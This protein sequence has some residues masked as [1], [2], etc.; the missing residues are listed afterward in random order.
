MST[1]LTLASSQWNNRPVDERYWSPADA[2][3][4]AIS[5]RNAAIETSVNY[6]D[7]RVIENGGEVGIVG[8]QGFPFKLTNYSFG[9]LCQRASAPAGFM[10]SLPSKMAVEVLNHKL[11]RTGVGQLLLDK[12]EGSVRALTGN[13]YTR[14]WNDSLL[15]MCDSL[16]Q[17]GW[18]V[19]P[20]RAR[21]S[22]SRTRPATENDIL[23]GSQHNSLA[24]RVGDS[25]APSGVYASDRDMFCFLVNDGEY[26]DNPA[27]PNTP[28]QR[29]FMLWNSEVGDKSLG[30]ITF[31]YDAVCGNHI[32]WG[33]VDVRTFR[34]RHV[35]NIN[36]KAEFNFDSVVNHRIDR[37]LLTD[38][39]SHVQSVLIG[40]DKE[41]VIS[42]AA[43]VTK[44]PKGTI[45][46]AYDIADGSTRYGDPRTPWG[47][48][49]GLTELSQK[50]DY[51]SQ[52]VAIDSA[53]GIL[54][55]GF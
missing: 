13:A 41:A 21:F 25:I 6:S 20:G 37:N 1:N 47:I 55:D 10:E 26:Y 38:Q 28:M 45:E 46:A 39:L 12:N 36:R 4:R 32:V 19:P 2:L 16:V 22:D 49:Q 35:G 53:A 43:T 23:K 18:K 7:L 48:S 40:A 42:K 14:V 17:R 8:K 33:A 5:A 44:L 54:L 15:R 31:L 11:D 9:Q 50:K 24:V 30:M 52:R 51:T 27:D 3:G 29:G 34:S